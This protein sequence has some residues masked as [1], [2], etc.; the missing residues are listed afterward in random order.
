M[1]VDVALLREQCRSA[2]GV[3]FRDNK[4]E[5]ILAVS[6]PLPGFP[7]LEMAEA[8]ALRRAILIALEHGFAR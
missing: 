2:V 3:V 7:S 6:E 5:C 1:N 4:G 8:M